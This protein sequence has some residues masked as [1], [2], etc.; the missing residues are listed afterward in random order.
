MAGKA[1]SSDR[2]DRLFVLSWGC[3]W[4]F[5]NRFP[6]CHDNGDPLRS[7]RS[8]SCNPLYQIRHK[9]LLD[10]HSMLRF[11]PCLCFLPGIAQRLAPDVAIQTFLD[12]SFQRLEPGIARCPASVDFIRA[13]SGAVTP[14][15]MAAP[16]AVDR[17]NN[18]DLQL[19]SCP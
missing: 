9:R 18:Y 11:V 17:M 13:R 12:G 16:L 10:T 2:V 8:Q 15:V 19:I 3:T 7:R 1:R 4:L 14:D 6:A 5:E